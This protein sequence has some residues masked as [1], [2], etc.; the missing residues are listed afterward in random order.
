[1][2]EAE[3]LAIEEEYVQFSMRRR[4]LGSDTENSYKLTQSFYCLI[5]LVRARVR[6]QH[7]LHGRGY[8]KPI[9]MLVCIQKEM[10]KC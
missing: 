9:N 8:Y 6:L 5:E 4:Y 3:E 10:N 2:T 7:P 1:M